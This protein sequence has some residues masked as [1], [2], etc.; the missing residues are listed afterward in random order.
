MTILRATTVV[1]PLLWAGLVL[2][3]SFLATPVK[4][5]AASLSLPVAL[6]VGSHTFH[7]LTRIEVGLGLILAAA[8][9]L[10][11]H[12]RS[13]S[14][15]LWCLPLAL[16]LVQVFAVL[17]PLDARLRLIVDGGTPGPSHLHLVYVGLESAKLCVLI[18]LGIWSLGQR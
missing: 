15:V 9:W 8:A 4:F 2:G 14:Y 16:V 11:A 3:V 13:W 5:R 10:P 1:L 12:L 17:P 7:L 18:G 6:E